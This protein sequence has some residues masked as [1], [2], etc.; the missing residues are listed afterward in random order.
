MNGKKVYQTIVEHLTKQ[1]F[2]PQLQRLDNEASKELKDLCEGGW[3]FIPA[4]SH[5]PD[6]ACRASIIG[7]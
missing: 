7:A 6:P 1:G 2:R 3:Q 4:H 5:P